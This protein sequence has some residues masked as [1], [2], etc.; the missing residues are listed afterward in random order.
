MNFVMKIGMGVAL[1]VTTLA[2]TAQADEFK[3]SNN[4]RIAWVWHSLWR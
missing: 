4:Q 2:S 1:S 3:L